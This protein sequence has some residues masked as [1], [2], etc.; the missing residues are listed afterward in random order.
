V[1]LWLRLTAMSSIAE[2]NAFTSLLKEEAGD[3]FLS[4]TSLTRRCCTLDS[5]IGKICPWF[6]QSDLVKFRICLVMLQ[7]YV[8]NDINTEENIQKT[9]KKHLEK[10]G[11]QLV[12]G[13]STLMK[14]RNTEGHALQNLKD[15]MGFKASKQLE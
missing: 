6:M 13:E 2:P 8:E 9:T 11:G 10:L 5:M 12:V 3:A 1:L 4:P 15:K 7:R 14:L